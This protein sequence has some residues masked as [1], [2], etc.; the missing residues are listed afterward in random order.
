MYSPEPSSPW[1]WDLY[2]VGGAQRPDSFTGMNADFRGS[3][4]SMFRGAPPEIQEELRVLSGYRSTERQQQ[5]WDDAL[6]RYGDPEIADNWV[7]RPGGSYHN[8]GLAADLRYLSPSA[9]E[10]VHANAGNYGLHFPLSNEPWHV[11]PVGARGNGGYQGSVAN[12]PDL[13]HAT[14]QNA[15]AGLPLDMGQ[16]DFGQGMDP[17]D[18]ML[19]TALNALTQQPQQ[20]QQP[21][22]SALTPY[23]M[24]D[25]RLD[26]ED[27][28]SRRRFG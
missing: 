3:L 7:A 14:P 15:L 21:Q 26:P 27:Y 9:R 20:Q 28:M 6:R 25:T 10:W 22:Q 16:P 24:V 19:M 8:H 1:N 13:A 4:E 11:E 2:A 18:A 5:L 17:R 12:D 23:S